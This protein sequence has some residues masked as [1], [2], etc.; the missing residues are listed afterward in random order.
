MIYTEQTSPKSHFP[1][2]H[3]PLEVFTL[4]SCSRSP[5]SLP[6]RRPPPACPASFLLFLAL[7]SCLLWPSWSFSLLSGLSLSVVSDS[8]WPHS[9]P[10]SSVHGDSPGKNTRVGCHSLLQGIFPIQGS[11][12]G[13][14]HWRWFLYLLSHQRSPI[15][16]TVL[17]Q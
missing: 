9:P 1:V 7:H 8:L 14:L 6:Q 15:N 17:I 11:N 4:Y 3:I 13:L 5:A 10:G 12:P 16:F 2:P